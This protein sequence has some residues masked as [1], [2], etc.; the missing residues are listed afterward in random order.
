M[1]DYRSDLTAAPKP[2]AAWQEEPDHQAEFPAHL[3]SLLYVTVIP[4]FSFSLL[5]LLVPPDLHDSTHAGL[6]PNSVSGADRYKP[7]ANMA[8]N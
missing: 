8:S 3:A 2:S 1:S 7:R 4:L 6:L 5:S